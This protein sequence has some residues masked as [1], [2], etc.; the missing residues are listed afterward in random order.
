MEAELLACGAIEEE[1]YYAGLARMYGLPFLPEIDPGLLVDHVHC[2]TQLAEPR[3]LRLHH[4]DRPPV[5]AVAA[6][7][8]HMDGLAQRFLRHGHSTGSLVVTTPSAIRGRSGRSVKPAGSRMPSP[9]CSII[10]NRCRRVSS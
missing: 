1:A 6:H 10:F 8:L 7:I 3:M 5:V 4:T 2:D 9:A